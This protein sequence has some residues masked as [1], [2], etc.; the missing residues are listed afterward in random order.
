MADIRWKGFGRRELRGHV[1]PHTGAVVEDVSPEDAE[2]LLQ[3]PEQ[4][5][6]LEEEPGASPE[7]SDDEEE[8]S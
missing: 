4:F 7:A 5:E 2:F 3:F 8:E 1:W 6:L